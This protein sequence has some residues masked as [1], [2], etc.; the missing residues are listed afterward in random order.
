MNNALKKEL[1]SS[2]KYLT[3][4]SEDGMDLIAT[5]RFEEY[6]ELTSTLDAVNNYQQLKAALQAILAVKYEAGMS[7]PYIDTIL[8][9]AKEALQKH[10]Q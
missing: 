3:N 1:V 10:S 8:G 5:F 6:G 2:C 4:I 7:R 9:I